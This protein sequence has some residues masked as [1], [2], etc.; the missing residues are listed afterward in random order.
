VAEA[1]DRAGEPT[2]RC[3]FVGEHSTGRNFVE[4]ADYRNSPKRSA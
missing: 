3:M 1:A 4:Q 2:N